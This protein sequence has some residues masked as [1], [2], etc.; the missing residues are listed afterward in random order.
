ML[1]WQ[2]KEVIVIKFN[3]VWIFTQIYVDLQ[4][5][6]FIMLLICID[7]QIGVQK[8]DYDR[9]KKA[10]AL[11]EKNYPGKLEKE[12]IQARK[13]LASL[14]RIRR[15]NLNHSPVGCI[16]THLMNITNKILLTVAR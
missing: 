12:L 6:L 10:I 14:E 15:Y 9:L 7:L 2:Q 13:F 11:V 1:S 4:I 3:S 8:R 5:P 16:L